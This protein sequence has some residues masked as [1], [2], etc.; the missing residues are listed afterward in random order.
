MP[1]PARQDR[2]RRARSTAGGMNR[3]RGTSSMAEITRR[4]VT[5]VVRTWPSTMWRRAAAKSVIAI[6]GKSME[7]A[8]LLC[9]KPWQKASEPAA[10]SIGAGSYIGLHPGEARGLLHAPGARFRRPRGGVVTQRT[11]NPCTPVR[12]RPWPP[13]FAPAELRLGDCAKAAAP[14]PRSGEGGPFTLCKATGLC[15]RPVREAPACSRVA[16]W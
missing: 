16:Q 10:L 2:D 4:S 3:S 15:Y 5:S 11:A 12:F 9:G 1:P 6:P 13:A 14:K 8:R 7:N